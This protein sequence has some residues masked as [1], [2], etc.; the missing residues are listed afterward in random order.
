[1]QPTPSLKS[2]LMYQR[3]QAA[4]H[5]GLEVRVVTADCRFT[6]IPTYLDSEF[7]EILYLH[8][9][10]TGEDV[11]DDEEPYLRSAWLIR[12]SEV[13]AVGY[14][15]SWSKQKLNT[16]IKANDSEA[17]HLSDDAGGLS[18]TPDS[19]ERPSQER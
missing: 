2:N 3:L 15:A 17:P 12:L 16:L 13:T 19:A 18:P 8:T 10:D 14:T 4:L 7:V 6:G 11:D 9:P 5:Q 1:M